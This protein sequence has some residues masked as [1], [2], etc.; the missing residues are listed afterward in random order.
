MLFGPDEY[1]HLAEHVNFC[2]RPIP[3]DFIRSYFNEMEKPLGDYSMN[4]MCGRTQDAAGN[5]NEI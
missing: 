5:E 3:G 4:P 1:R 2:G